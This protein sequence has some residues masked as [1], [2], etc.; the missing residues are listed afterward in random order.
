MTAPAKRAP[1]VR[2]QPR[3]IQINV[4]VTPQLRDA[5]RG[6]LE[7]GHYDQ[8]ASYMGNEAF[9]LLIKEKHSLPLTES[10][11]NTKLP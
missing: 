1:I 8:S 10:P 5:I 6:V 7:A 11:V 9:K 2:R 4:Y 3:D